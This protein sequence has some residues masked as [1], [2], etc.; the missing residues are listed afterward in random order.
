[1]HRRLFLR[2]GSLVL[3]AACLIQPRSALAAAP[4]PRLTVK[5]DLILD[6]PL[7][8]LKTDGWRQGRG[9]WK[10]AKGEVTGQQTDPE[11][12]YHASISRDV[13][14]DEVAGIIEGEVKLDGANACWLSLGGTCALVMSPTRISFHNDGAE[15]KNSPG[16][17]GAANEIRQGKWYPFIIE[18]SG[19][20]VAA[21]RERA[22]IAT[23]HPQFKQKR[24]WINFVVSSDVE[25]GG[26]TAS[27][28]G[29]KIYR[30]TPNPAWKKPKA[31]R[32][33]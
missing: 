13:A 9:E 8:D 1:M 22:E 17:S 11:P 25:K 24:T 21:E 26:G 3:G 12:L 23:E 19:V 33:R 16:V 15:M 2:H 5:G 20:E 4:K 7:V 14:F 31:P 32:R 29:L 28:R 6:A 10:V 18:Y 27:L 30:A